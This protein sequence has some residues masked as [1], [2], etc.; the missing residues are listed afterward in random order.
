MLKIIKFTC[1]DLLNY[2][3]SDNLHPTFSFYVE[4]TNNNVEL[5]NIEL[6]INNLSLSKALTKFFPLLIIEF[7]IVTFFPLTSIVVPI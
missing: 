4:S 7:L 3:Q 1:E 2:C 6:S 5:T